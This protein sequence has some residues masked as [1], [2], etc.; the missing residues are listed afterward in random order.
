MF[1]LELHEFLHLSYYFQG[2]DRG[3]EYIY[4]YKP[5]IKTHLSDY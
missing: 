2:R 4:N 1:P 3:E 5:E